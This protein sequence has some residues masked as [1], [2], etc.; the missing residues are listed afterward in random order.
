MDH[1][2]QHEQSWSRVTSPENKR[3]ATRGNIVCKLDPGSY[4]KIT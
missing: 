2:H 1:K 3:Y 4:D